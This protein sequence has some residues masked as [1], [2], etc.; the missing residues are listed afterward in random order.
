MSAT[1]VAVG[2][3][4]VI[5]LVGVVVPVLPGVF[6]VLGA[7]LVWALERQDGVG[8]TVLAVTLVLFA[9]GQVAKYLVPGRQ[10][11][12][13]GVPARVTGAGVVLGFVGFFVLP[14]VGLPVGFVL[15]IYL[16]QR[17]RLKSH[18]RAWPSTQQA[19]RAA[20]WSMLLELATALLMAA[21][22]GAGVALAAAQGA[23]DAATGAFT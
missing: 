22:W 18:A 17:L 12:H 3:V 13:A 9:I 20:G 16:A 5:G 10:L 1:D 19:L 23:G 7:I 6:L 4:I 14:V 21:I 11:K 8:W 2:L 15:G